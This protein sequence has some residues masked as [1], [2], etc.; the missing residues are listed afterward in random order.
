MSALVHHD[1]FDVANDIDV[2]LG[3]AATSIDLANRTVTLDGGRRLQFAKLILATGSTP[4]RP[5]IPGIDLEHVHT[6]RTIDDAIALRDRLRPGHRLAV[7]G[8]SWIGTEVA[9]CARQRGCDVV[10]IGPQ[11]T[12]LERVLGPEVGSQFAKMHTDQGVE[13]FMGSGVAAIVGA[14]EVEGVRL[15]NGMTL[16]ADTVV[17]GTG[18]APNVQLA[19]DAGLEVD[20]GVLVD[21]SLAAS[22]PD[23]YAVGDIAN[24]V[25]PLLGRRVRV[26]HWAN[27]LHQGLLGGANAAGARLQYDNIPYFYSDQYDMSLEYSGWPEPWQRVVFRSDPDTGA[28]VAFYLTDGKVVGGLNVNVADVNEYVQALIRSA[29]TVDVSMLTDLNVEPAQ[30]TQQSVVRDQGGLAE[31]SV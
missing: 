24:A 3:A 15:D 22:H 28:Y 31:R 27:A 8:A 10:M 14:D 1:S 6:F 5:P 29:R 23:V 11:A 17:V 7:I 12:P 16:D 13:L 20:N 18:V 9:A 25:H 2:L 26:E 19:V 21:A 30:W 4:R